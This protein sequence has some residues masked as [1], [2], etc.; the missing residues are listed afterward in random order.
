M[1]AKIFEFS[2][3]CNEYEKLSALERSAI[4]TGKSVKILAKLR[5]FGVDEVDPVETLAAFILGS[6][7]ADGK[8]NE[9]EYIL[10]YPALVKVFGSDFNFAKVKA[11]VAKNSELKKAAKDYTKELMQLLT[12]TDESFAIDVIGLCLCVVSI[13]GKISLRE[14]MYIGKLYR[15]SINTQKQKK[16]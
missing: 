8:L 4:L 7:V 5:L 13:D 11:A 16:E 3:L 10:M 9:Q 12:K 15:C 6:I 14:K 1:F 2:K